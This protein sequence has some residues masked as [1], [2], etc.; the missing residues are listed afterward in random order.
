MGNLGDELKK[1]G[2]ISDKELRRKRHEDRV[3]RKKVGREGLQAEQQKTREEQQ[4][5]RE[6]Q[7]ARNRAVE[8]ERRS[9]T[10]GAEARAQ[11]RDLIRSR[12]QAWKE[13]A[14]RRFHF[15]DPAGRCPYMLVPDAVA[16]RLE[17][18]ELGI[19]W[20]EG[21]PAVVDRD[22]AQRVADLDAAAL[23]FLQGR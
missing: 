10:S 22:T 18:G 6:E 20:L 8:S 4:R 17:A 1:A 3:H 15:Q 7:R 16:R 13:P 5:R 14:T 9:Q 19:T 11:A 12:A 21:C 2:L 23:L